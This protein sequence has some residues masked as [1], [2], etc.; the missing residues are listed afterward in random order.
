[1]ATLQQWVDGAR[2]RTLPAAIAPVLVGTGSAYAMER[3][4]PGLGLLAA[5]VAI[6]LRAPFIVVVVLAAAT[7][8]ALRA[9]GIG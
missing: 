3:A 5:I 7:A 4:N 6:A 1:M 9:F 8:A 2:P